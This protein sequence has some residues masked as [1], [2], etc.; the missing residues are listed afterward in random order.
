MMQTKL[1]CWEMKSCGREPNGLNVKE[2]GVCPAS[3]DTSSNGLNGGKNAGRI[4]WAVSG[5]FCG[6]EVQGSFAQKKMSCMS[7]EVYRTVQSEETLSNF[8]LMKPGK[9]YETESV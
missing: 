7:C 9:K 5:T 1:N 8:K 2:L 4:C 6:G 3:T